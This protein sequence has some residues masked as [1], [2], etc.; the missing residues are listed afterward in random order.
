MKEKFIKT[1]ALMSLLLVILSITFKVL[2]QNQEILGLMGSTIFT[3]FFMM[4]FMHL[5]NKSKKPS[6]ILYVLTFLSSMIPI[7]LT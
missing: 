4:L 1:F 5:N 2:D 3:L 6:V 7:W